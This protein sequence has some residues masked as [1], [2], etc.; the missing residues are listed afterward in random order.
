[1]AM[2]SVLMRIDETAAEP[3]LSEAR[4]HRSLS[5]ATG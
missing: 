1:M 4:A 2:E 5:H 3:H